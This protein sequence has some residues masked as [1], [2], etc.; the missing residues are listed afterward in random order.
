MLFLNKL[1]N[2]ILGVTHHFPNQ[3]YKI[4]Y[5][6]TCGG[7]DFFEMNDIFNMPYQRALK[8]TAAY[9]EIRMKCTYEY[10]Q[11]YQKAIANELGGTK[12]GMKN[13]AKI[14]TL[15][16]QLGERLSKWAIDLNHVYRLASIVYFDKS[17]K[18]E[19]YDFKYADEKIAL[20]KKENVNDFFLQ[21][22]IKRLIPFIADAEVN[23][24]TYSEIIK[25]MSM[26]HLDSVRGSLSDS[27]KTQFNAY[28]SSLYAE[29][30]S[31]N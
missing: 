7:V 11:W 6:F 10:L 23:L 25:Q 21:L 3:K 1:K 16:A 24:K 26:I 18:P 2:K 9:E 14:Q 20:W 31:P 28:V 13:A 8:A 22:P 17:E 4:D 27:Q 12:F 5:A 30:T 19:V 15:N 29:E